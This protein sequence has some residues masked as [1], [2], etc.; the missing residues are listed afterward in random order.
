MAELNAQDDQ[1]FD[2]EQ[3]ARS[4]ASLLDEGIA[5]PLAE[6]FKALADPTRIRIISMLAEHELSVGE[7]AAALEMSLSAISH[8]LSLLRKM[9]IVAARRAGRRVYYA[10]DDEHV[11]QLYHL[12]LEHVAHT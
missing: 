5:G 7:L 3:L 11:E 12:G 2:V 1:G 4:R 10:L 8:Q 9:R 6:T